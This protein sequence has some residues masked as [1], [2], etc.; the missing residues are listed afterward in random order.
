MASNSIL[1]SNPL[2]TKT[3]GSSCFSTLPPTVST[4]SLKE[5]TKGSGGESSVVEA[6]GSSSTL[7][8]LPSITTTISL[9]GTTKGSGEESLMDKAKKFLSHYKMGIQLLFKNRRE[10][11]AIQ[12][13][14]VAENRSW[15]RREYQLITLASKDIR[16]LFPF[17]TILFI[18]PES[19]PFLLIFAP[20]L[21]PSTCIL[22][23]QEVSV[24]F[25][26][27]RTFFS[28]LPFISLPTYPLFIFPRRND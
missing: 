5:P 1:S 21:V 11:K 15:T 9:T 7:S 8:T 12:K 20:G 17:L 26:V 18:L 6:K 10:A 13:A 19:I 23:S 28:P 2:M 3:K 16:K 24:F 25:L 14:L 22:P 27:T 4:I